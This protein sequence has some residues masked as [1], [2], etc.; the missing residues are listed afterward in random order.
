MMSLIEVFTTMY[1]IIFVIQLEYLNM[2]Q[3][4]IF[5][6]LNYEFYEWLITF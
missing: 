3:T 1:H 6:I 2:N 4:F 5:I